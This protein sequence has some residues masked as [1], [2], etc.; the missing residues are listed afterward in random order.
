MTGC[1]RDQLFLPHCHLPAAT[2]TTSAAVLTRGYRFA[3]QPACP[4]KTRPKLNGTAIKQ[5]KFRNTTIEE[6]IKK[7]RAKML[8]INDIISQD[9]IKGHGP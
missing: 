7:E 5:Q 3:T 9:E 8:D 6:N 1:I 4:P 2:T